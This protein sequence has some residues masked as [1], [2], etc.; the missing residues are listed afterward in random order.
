VTLLVVNNSSETARQTYEWFHQ[1][2]HRYVGQAV[3]TDDPARAAEETQRIEPLIDELVGSDGIVYAPSPWHAAFYLEMVQAPGEELQPRIYRGQSDHTWD[4]VPAIKRP[5]TDLRV[6]ALAR[7][8]FVSLARALQGQ[9]PGIT[10]P[11]DLAD[12]A[13]AQHYGIR[14]SLLDFSVNPHVAVYFACQARDPEPGQL[15]AVFELD[16]ERIAQFGARAFYSHPLAD[17]IYRQQGLFIDMSY[18]ARSYLREWCREVRFPPDRRFRT[19]RHGR[20]VELLRE[21]S[22][23]SPLTDLAL[24]WA[25]SSEDELSDDAVRDMASELATKLP[26]F[27]EVGEL[28]AWVTEMSEILDQLCFAPGE[29]SPNSIRSTPLSVF[30]RDN[31]ELSQLYY[32][33]IRP[34]IGKSRTAKNDLMILA[35]ERVLRLDQPSAPDVR[36]G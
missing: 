19:F 12:E 27:D 31:R 16:F 11:L 28:A 7:R 35:F 32:R 23:F 24:R 33:Q 17:R 20:P 6:T 2:P 25:V 13:T 9:V 30:V 36:S 1:H 3:Y 5:D 34:L 8:T 14:T 4:I 18:C 22:V 10:I 15:A 21:S 26:N 29:E